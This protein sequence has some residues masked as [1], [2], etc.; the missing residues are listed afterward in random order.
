[1]IL[2]CVFTLALVGSF[3][4]TAAAQAPILYP[5]NDSND[6]ALLRRDLR[7]SCAW[8]RSRCGGWRRYE[9]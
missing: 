1:M 3:P 6:C 2:R 7:R 4:F 8:R 9:P 5:S